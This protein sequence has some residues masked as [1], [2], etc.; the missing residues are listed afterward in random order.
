MALAPGF[1]LGPFEIVAP[2]GAGGMGVVYS[3][4][5]TRLERT[6]AIKLLPPGFSTN[7]VLLQRFER[8]ARSASALNHPNIVTIYELGIDGSTPYIA[9]ELV[10]GKT[11]RQLLASGLMPMRK[12]IEI[13]VQIAEGLTKAHEAGITHRDLKPENIMV[14]HDKFVKILDF[15]LAKQVASSAEKRDAFATSTSVTATGVIVGTIGYMSPEQVSGQAVDFRSDHFSFG[16]MLYEMVVGKRPFE[17]SNAAET[18]VAIL[19]DE[20][21]PVASKNRD[22]PAPLCW[23]IERCLAKEPEKRYVST[24]DLARELAAIR[25]CFSEDSVK[26]PATRAAHL[27]VARTGFVGREKEVA[28]TKELLMRQD[29]RLVTVTGPGGIGKTRLAVEVAGALSAGFV[30]GIHFVPL[31]PLNDPALVASVIV[32]TLGIREVGGQS[33]LETL[34]KNLQESFR[35]PMLLLLDNFEHLVPAAPTV[36][37]LLAVAPNLKILVTSRAALH[38]Y[39][40]HEFPV[41]PLGLPDWRSPRSLDVLSQ[42]PAVALF[43]Q[44][45]SAAKPDFELNQENASAV[46]EICARL[47]GLPLAIELAAARVKV[48]SPSSM[49]TRL[50]SRLQLL[51]GGARD[52]PQRQQTLRAAIDWSYELLNA[53]EQNL[54]RRLAA[55][56]GGC[57]LEGVEA[58]CDARGDLDLDLLDGMASMVDKSLAQQ[59][60]TPNGESRFVM[61]E[62]IR[63]YALEKLTASGEGVSTKRAHA[64]YC[65][66]LA[67]EEATEQSGV[68]RAAWLERCALEHDNLRAGLEWLIETGNA[69]WGLRLGTALFRFWE[70]RD[71]QTEGRDQL[72]RLL[73]LPGAAAPTKARTRALFAAGILAGE[74][75]DYAS[76]DALIGESRDIA[77][78]LGD[79]TGVAVSLNALAVL[80]RDRGDVPKAHALFEESL[81]LWREVG[82]LKAVARAL[83]N[84]ANTVKL[85]GDYERSRTLYAECLSIFRGLGDRTGVGWSLNYQGDAARDQGDFA[86]ARSLYERALAIFSELADRWGIAG[87]LADLGSLAREQRDFSTAH[88][89]YRESIKIFQELEHKR[90][91]ARLL[92]CFACSAAAQLDAERSLRLAGAAAALRQNIGAP[93]TLTERI[94]L[95]D[96]LDA[97]RKAMSNTAGT[98]AYLQGWALPLEKAIEEVRLPDDFGWSQGTI[99]GTS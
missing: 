67:E 4:R 63:E 2:L 53:A 27:P 76:A 5:D 58:V 87:T 43:V 38:V 85:L 11:L 26:Q 51:T 7:S 18:M 99:A 69:D 90:G 16:L 71:Y 1:R 34:K 78:R 33:P 21:E 62:T 23:V 28:A 25:D 64:A 97:A 86:S 24:R 10:E 74:Q 31:S 80:T 91:I 45:A 57:N 20:A 55:F 70:I 49:R 8:E 59:V 95:E 84:L 37:E 68:E 93:L 65:L 79:K 96:S 54:L 47:D 39:G 13:A 44:R 75:G 72:G 22:A 17:R 56:V 98:T 35:A 29:V 19:R 48:L 88:S 50:A 60:E 36:A 15:G 82:D 41:P 52:L 46:A 42:S 6:V 92:E 14:S 89:L 73:K 30:G 12:A 81:L 9:M 94:K 77:R 40:E 3:A 61:L 83:S 66:V 32:Q